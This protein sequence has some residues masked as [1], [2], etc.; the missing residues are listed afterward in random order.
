MAREQIDKATVRRKLAPRREPYWGAPVERGLFVGFRRLEHG[1]N[2]VARWRDD[3]G[4]Q[5]Y[6]AIGPVTDAM[7]YD[8]A[9]KAAR[10]WQRA[11]ASGVDTRE[12]RTVSDVCRDYT[13][14]MGAQGRDRAATDTEK[15]F[16]RIIHADPIGNLRADK[17]TQRH[18]EAWRDR[19]EAGEMTGRKSGT[20]SRATINRNLTSLKA[21]LNRAVSRREIPHERAVE[22]DS[23]KPHRGADGRRELFL[24][25]EQ[26]RALLN[27]TAG[28][29]R[30]LLTCIALTGCRPGD[31][32]AMLRKDYDKRTGSVTFRTKTGA[33]TIPVSPAAKELF[34]RLAKSKL[35]TALMFTNAGEPWTPQAWAPKVKAAAAKAELPPETVA[36][37]LRHSWITSAIIGGMDPVTVARLTGT[38]LEM[39]SRTY[40][41]LVQDAARERLAQVSFV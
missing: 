11:A 6:F 7:D 5:R 23:I 39:I 13:D 20:P 37:T 19:M 9:K 34:D 3:E 16:Y 18:I 28:D 21:A 36:Y 35:P 22:W 24:D 26:R 38:S 17:L 8:A 2:W 31:P 30:D 4:K 40:G 1:G 14:A 33:R 29:L 41:H 27:A 10:Q 25:L 12:V 32:A 15:R